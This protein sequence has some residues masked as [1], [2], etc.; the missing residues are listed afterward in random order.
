ML[1]CT[2]GRRLVRNSPPADGGAVEVGWWGRGQV[3]QKMNTV[4]FIFFLCAARTVRTRRA[5]SELRRSRSP[6]CRQTG[7][8]CPEFPLWTDGRPDGRHT[9][10]I[11]NRV[12][13]I[14]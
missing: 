11:V 3:V 14:C 4:S 2:K 7:R 12:T 13:V 1:R 5:E 6:G 8:T 10:D 9:A